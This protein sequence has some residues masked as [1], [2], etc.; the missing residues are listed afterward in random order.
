MFLNKTAAGTD[1]GILQHSACS[2]VK[3]TS[4]CI[5]CLVNKPL[6][7]SGDHLLYGITQCYLPPDRGDSPDF[8]PGIHQYSFYRPRRVEG[9]VDLGTAGK[10]LQPVPK[11]VVNKVEMTAWIRTMSS[12]LR[13]LRTVSAA[14]WTALS[15][16]SRGCTTFSSRM[17]VIAPYTQSSS[18][19]Y[20][21]HYYDHSVNNISVFRL[22]LVR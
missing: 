12:I 4:I 13:M 18:T 15:D 20:H 22:P 6:M 21:Y 10:V 9:W 17:F 2:K 8:T 1:C 5:A 11:T 19:R 14:R 7:R 16:T 3:L